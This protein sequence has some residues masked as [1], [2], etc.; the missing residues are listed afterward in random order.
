MDREDR[1]FIEKLDRIFSRK[2][3]LRHRTMDGSTGKTSLV[4]LTYSALGRSKGF[5]KF[6]NY[7]QQHG[8]Q[9]RMAQ[10]RLLYSTYDQMENSPEICCVTG[11]T[12]IISPFHTYTIKELAEMYNNSDEKF[13]IYAYDIEK[14]G[15]VLAKAHHPRYTKTD[16]VWK[17]TFD[18][19]TF[20]TA[21]SDHKFLMRNGE[22]VEVKDLHI[23]DK[24]MP[25][26]RKMKDD[27]K[28]IQTF[29]C[30]W[31]YEHRF[32]AEQIKGDKLDKYPNEIV[33]HIDYNKSNNLPENL[34]ICS[35]QEHNNIH[36][37]AWNEDTNIDKEYFIKIAEKISEAN[38]G[39]PGWQTGLTK[40]TDSR[41][42]GWSEER[43]KMQKEIHDE[44]WK[45]E[46]YRIATTAHLIEYGKSEE[47]RKRV[48]KLFSDINQ[49]RKE[50][51]DH[52]IVKN[53]NKKIGESNKKTR[54]QWSEEY[55]KE[56][57]Q[58]CSAAQL[59]KYSN[60]SAEERKNIYGHSGEKNGRYG[61]GY[62]T[63]GSKNGRYL[64]G[65]NRIE[66]INFKEISIDFANKLSDTQIIEKYNLVPTQLIEIKSTVRKI[67]GIRIITDLNTTVIENI[68]K[69]RGYNDINEY[70]NATNH[71]IVNIE[72]AGIQEVYDLTT[73]IYHNF[74]TDSI[75]IHNSGLD[76]LA[77]EVTAT[78]EH[79][80]MIQVICDDEDK[81]K[82]IE[83]LY[84]D[85]LNLDFNLWSW[86]R[87]LLKYGD[88]GLLLQFDEDHG[89][90]SFTTVPAWLFDRDEGTNQN[91]DVVSFRITGL[92]EY[93]PYQFIH[94]RLLGDIRYLPYGRSYLEPSR[95]IWKHLIT[96][97]DSM[98]VYRITRAPERRV[99]FIDVGDISPDEVPAFMDNVKM[100]IK[101][102]LNVDILTGNIDYRFTSM[103]A[104]QD[105][106]IPTTSEKTSTRIETLPG[107]QNDGITEEV[108]YLQNKLFAGLKIPKSYLTYEEALSGKGSLSNEDIRFAKTV[109]RIQKAICAEL[110]KIA[111][112]H[113]Y[114]LGYED[115][116]LSDYEIKL[117]NPSSVSEKLK[118]ELINSKVET[119][120]QAIVGGLSRKWGYENIWEISDEE[121]RDLQKEIIK[122]AKFQG[123]INMI[124]QE[125]RD[126]EGEQQLDNDMQNNKFSPNNNYSQN[127]ADNINDAGDSDMTDVGDDEINN[128]YGDKRVTE[129]GKI[130]TAGLVRKKRTN[131]IKQLNESYD[132]ELRKLHKLLRADDIKHRTKGR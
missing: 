34:L 101:S 132:I 121:A 87:N 65:K 35:A 54:A 59:K 24:C 100:Q 16:H 31:Q 60:M 78:N 109:S 95:V 79:G 125:G 86:T 38:K 20:L 46:K 10:R 47:N 130:V 57:S 55:Q 117:S 66:D 30:G 114:C 63:S 97:E 122:D 22:Y 51:P 67:W 126:P 11:D 28:V 29:N 3:V 91:P 99:Y 72:Y 43:R 8:M 112:I 36:G 120:N 56:V 111:L 5:T 49:W 76:L 19:G 68:V 32:V 52:E 18:D 7:L 123:R 124:Q 93:K 129:P 15:L 37:R 106:F 84:Y 23:N 98:L 4:K 53:I 44:L 119:F 1:S 131:S 103:N 80:E 40:E 62:L 61:K 25:F 39:R 102:D 64:H 50:N 107:G 27:R 48:S 83:S 42:H 41:I 81:K 96:L 58:I 104:I 118:L 14:K 9:N 45:D 110:K 89:I 71:C 13:W 105:F 75:I 88:F 26:M 77:D 92:G 12:K 69:E 74:A 82:I 70:I 128:P 94:F 108:T 21:T 127:A 73:D 17:I 6:S 33:H 85:I 90:Y 2:S 116:E 113:L 115:S